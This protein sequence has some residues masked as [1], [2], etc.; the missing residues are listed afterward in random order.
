MVLLNIIKQQEATEHQDDDTAKDLQELIELE[1]TVGII[2]VPPKNLQKQ[3]TPQ[4]ARIKNWEPKSGDWNKPF[5]WVRSKNN[6]WIG[7]IQN[8]INNDDELKNVLNVLSKYGT[9]Y[10]VGGSVRDIIIG[11]VSKDFDIEVYG[12]PIE[13]LSN[14]LIEELGARGEQVGKQ[15]GIFK[16]GNFDISLPRQEVKTGEKHTDFDVSPDENLS[17]KIAARRRD[18]TINALMYNYKKG[19]IEDF[20]GG[21]ED[22]QNNVIRHIDDKTFIEDPLRVY[23]AAQFASRFG[24]RIDPKTIKLASTM[25]LSFLPPERIYE[26]FKKLLIKSPRPS[27]GIQALDDMGVIAKYFP[28]INNLKKTEQRPDYHA[29]GDVY[30]HTKMV[31]DEAAKIIGEWKE[32]ED[33]NIIMLTALAHDFGKPSTTKI[34]DKGFPVQPGH[35]EAG[36]KPTLKF[37][38]K[39]TNDKKITD[40]V[41]WIV[42][43]HLL[44][45]HL[46]RSKDETTDS[47]FKRII[48]KYS[49]PKLK[50]LAAVARADM[51]GR[52][53]RLED[54]TVIAPEANEVDWFLERID[55]VLQKTGQTSEG[56]IVP[57]V[58]GKDLINLGYTEGPYL[59]KILNDMREKYEDGSIENKEHAIQ[60]INENYNIIKSLTK[61]SLTDMDYLIDFEDSAGADFITSE[62]SLLQNIVNVGDKDSF[63]NDYI[64]VFDEEENLEAF[65]RFDNDLIDRTFTINSLVI[66]PKDSENIG[67][68]ARLLLSIISHFLAQ[69][70]SI[71]LRIQPF[72]DSSTLYYENFGFEKEGDYHIMDL[73]KATK[74]HEDIMSDI[75]DDDITLPNN[76]EKNQ[77][78]RLDH[79]LLQKILRLEKKLGPTGTLAGV[80]LDIAIQKQLMPTTIK[81]AID[82]NM[83]PQSGNWQYPIKWISKQVISDNEINRAKARGLVPKSGDWFKPMR[84][85]KP[86]SKSKGVEPSTTSKELEQRSKDLQD[87]AN[88][89]YNGGDVEY[90]EAMQQDLIIND[91]TRN[92]SSEEIFDR[93]EAKWLHSSPYYESFKEWQKNVN[94]AKI[95]NKK[96][97][98]VISDIQ[99]FGVFLKHNPD[100]EIDPVDG[101]KILI[102]INH[103]S[104]EPISKNIPL[105]ILEE[106]QNVLSQTTPYK[107]FLAQKEAFSKIRN[108]TEKE[109]DEEYKRTGQ[110]Q[111]EI[112]KDKYN[113][114]VRLTSND[115]LEI[116]SF[117]SR[118]KLLRRLQ[119]VADLIPNKEHLAKVK[120][121]TYFD[122]DTKESFKHLDMTPVGSYYWR[123]EKIELDEKYMNARIDDAVETITHEIG[124]A[125]NNN[126]KFWH[127]WG[128]EWQKEYEK[129]TQENKGFPSNYSRTSGG[130]FFA[131]WYCLFLGE[132]NK[133]SGPLGIEEDEVKKRKYTGKRNNHLYKRNKS[134]FRL[135]EDMIYDMDNNLTQLAPSSIQKSHDLDKY[136]YDEENEVTID[137]PRIGQFDPDLP[138]MSYD[139]EE[140]DVSIQKQLTPQQ[141]QAKGW[142]PQ[143]GNWSKPGRWIKSGKQKPIEEVSPREYN[144]AI[145]RDYMDESFLTKA[146][147]LEQ[148]FG[149]E[150]DHSFQDDFF[151]KEQYDY[152]HDTKT[153]DVPNL[154]MEEFLSLRNYQID[155]YIANYYAAIRNERLFS[156]DKNN[157]YLAKFIQ[158][159]DGIFDKNTAPSEELVLYRGVPQSVSH[160]VKEL[161]EETD[162]EDAPYVN[163]PFMSTSKNYHR[164]KD[165]AHDSNSQIIIKVVIP[166]NILPVLELYKMSFSGA[167][168]SDELDFYDELDFSGEEEVLL[169]RNIEFKINRGIVYEIEELNSQIEGYIF[170]AIGVKNFA[171]EKKS[172]QKQLSSSAPYNT[173]QVAWRAGSETILPPKT[174]YVSDADRFRILAEEGKLNYFIEEGMT[175]E[176]WTRKKQ[177]AAEA[178]YE[179]K[180]QLTPQEAQARGWEPQS[181]DWLAPVRWIRPEGDEFDSHVKRSLVDFTQKIKDAIDF[182]DEEEKLSDMFENVDMEH[183]NRETRELEFINLKLEELQYI[184]DLPSMSLQD[185]EFKFDSSGKLRAFADIDE[186]KTL[187]STI[188]KI[189]SVVAMP[190]SYKQPSANKVGYG[191]QLMM[192]LVHRFLTESDSQEIATQPLTKHVGKYYEK[193]GFYR[194]EG[195]DYMFM[196]REEAKESYN[197]WAKKFN[198]DLLK[199]MDTVYNDIDTAT[200]GIDKELAEL[201]ELENEA[202]ILA[203][204]MDN[205]ENFGIQKEIVFPNEENTL[206]CPACGAGCDCVIQLGCN[207]THD[208][209]CPSIAIC[210][211]FAPRLDVDNNILLD[212]KKLLWQ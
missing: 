102:T 147:E 211:D 30:I 78:D 9:P 85:I 73:D 187:N 68:T 81:E 93:L 140:E 117:D 39:I 122:E 101:E 76:Y 196:N 18:F 139:D 119:I 130:E 88:F 17:L 59:G 203:G 169:P 69:E 210:G 157:S 209:L 11:N 71:Q 26:E 180:K 146:R 58:T 83:E 178:M 138:D 66:I 98:N 107:N 159:V 64:F 28:E 126:K 51:K 109:R 195:Q 161:Y 60:Y 37:L 176:E 23:R 65:C 56:R 1:S 52:F 80:P 104:E 24:F 152:Y 201:I 166:P 10:L 57:L 142:E 7:Q 25:D 208:C 198:V 172:L 207:C 179:I 212:A 84:W 193:F 141:A 5:R 46:H 108:R 82:M 112:I 162:G 199:S 160:T 97:I 40:I 158:I 8:I 194:K 148:K 113:E 184:L 72:N 36:V 137:P 62:T 103:F 53:H 48:N 151:I 99:K 131:E 120:T 171:P 43:Q 182:E 74:I 149:L 77:L 33:K 54:G 115:V 21:L 174:G 35:E 192:D 45:A 188:F 61:S 168:M 123:D 154:N 205:E 94:E 55:E 29:E 163:G 197:K 116:S 125:V 177:E 128:G 143:S 6:S 15:F 186:M 13:K 110:H 150:E 127:I 173:G 105:H 129:A 191:V 50:L 27:I 190:N 38:S 132:K 12:V 165:F 100:M 89:V 63:M 135:L 183:D 153:D 155:S 124:H 16:I 20:F 92:F 181:R 167:T 114:L 175:N 4:Q 14:I 144:N 19:K 90:S 111:F 79:S 34:S 202:G 96:K 106:Y 87:F 44:P 2:S 3:L 133:Y 41:P 91:I 185:Y 49:V 170:T 22:L 206:H 121:I 134:V 118:T 145:D 32:D 200:S 86:P 95:E 136:G 75:F 70:D 156:A 47:T 42:S 67:C 204:S 164:A 189:H 31:V